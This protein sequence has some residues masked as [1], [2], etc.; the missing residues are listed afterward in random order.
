MFEISGKYTK[1]KVMIDELEA[2]CIAQITKLCNHPAFTNP[3][4]IMSD[5]HAGKGSCIGFT[6]E[7]TEK[8]IPQVVS[9]DIGCGMLGINI[10]KTFPLTLEKADKKI[11][12]VVPFGFDTHEKSIINVEK[13]FPWRDV[14]TL[15]HNFSLAY[16]KKFGTNFYPKQK[17]DYRWFE[18]KLDQIGASPSRVLKSFGTLGG[19]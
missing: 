13:D 11:R 2:S 17:Y 4:A 16:N 18:S 6:M 5:A 15:A 19:G 9:V 1:A 3:I 12:Q 8:V 10:G 7:L 14:N